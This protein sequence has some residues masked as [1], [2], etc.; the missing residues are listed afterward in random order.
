MKPLVTVIVVADYA[1]GEGATYAGL[2]AALHALSRQTYSGSVE[3]I[4][5][6]STRFR[7]QVPADLATILRD[8]QVVFCATPDSLA[9]RNEG[10]RLARGDV[11][12]FLDADCIPDPQ[13]LERMMETMADHPEA[14]V[15]SG[16]TVYGGASLMERTFSLLSRAYVDRGGAGAT[17]YISNNN[18]AFRRAVL[19]AH[20]FPTS[21]NP[22]V[23]ALHAGAILAAHGILW[24]DPEARVVHA[25]GGWAF[26]NEVSRNAG[27]ATIAVRQVASQARL[28]W[29]V[30]LGYAAIPVFVLVAL[31]KSWWRL[32]RFGPAYGLAWYELPIGFTVATVLCAMQAPG[33]WKALSGKPVV[34]TRYR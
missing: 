8:V 34:E 4:V 30:R 11:V 22:F 15:V 12:V 20:P 33:M 19:L 9:L 26:E 6:E 17:R 27:W 29:L 32:C 14:S 25:Y 28:A 23:M 18:V 13:W 16:R 5:V 24:F 7:Q 31:L 2:R 3:H 10:V 1:A 21:A